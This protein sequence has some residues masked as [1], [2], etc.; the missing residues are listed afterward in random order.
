[1]LDDGRDF[2]MVDVVALQAAHIG[3]A[4][5]AGEQWF[6][7]EYLLDAT[8]ARVAADVDDGRAEDEAVRRVRAFGVCV[9]L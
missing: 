9:V 7:A 6:F 5:A 3:D 1:M 2:Q 4:H 8:P